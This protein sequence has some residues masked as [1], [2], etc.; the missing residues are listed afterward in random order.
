MG[1]RILIVIGHPDSNPGRFCR[2]LAAS[3]SDGAISAGHFVEHID[4]SQLDFPLLRSANDFRLGDTPDALRHAAEAVGNAQHLVFVFPLWLGTMP[5][6][7]KGFLEQ[8]LR[9]GMAFAYSGGQIGVS[10]TL[11]DGRSA[12]L[13]VTMGSPSPFRRFLD[14]AHGLS[15]M[16]SH[17]LRFAGIGPV[18]HTM[19]GLVGEV[20]QQQRAKWLRKMRR[21]GARAA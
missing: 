4:I 20:D 7:L 2:A 1:K 21:L 5:A 14:Y 19:L 12:R 18:R 8:I 17:I 11:L 3:Y 16:H 9:P 6:L 15:G 13:V 10:E